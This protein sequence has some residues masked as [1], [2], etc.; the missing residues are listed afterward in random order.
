MP[1]VSSATIS[2]STTAVVSFT[3]DKGGFYSAALQVTN[4]SGEISQVATVTID[5]VATGDNHPPVAIA[6]A[7]V[8]VV[9]AT[10]GVA[11]LD[12]SASHDADGDD[13]T[14]RW[15]LLGAPAGAEFDFLETRTSTAQLNPKL[16]GIYTVELEVSDGID[17]DHDLIIVTAQ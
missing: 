7:D 15:F 4:E 14:F 17:Q 10:T 2:P 6:G 16:A 13:L 5:A 12:G 11:A 9:I 3:A 8:T 1:N